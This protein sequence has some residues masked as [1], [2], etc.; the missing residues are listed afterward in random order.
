MFFAVIDLLEFGVA[1]A[2]CFQFAQQEE[3]PCRDEQE[4]QEQ[5]CGPVA[6][7]FQGTFFFLDLEARLHFL[8]GFILFLLDVLLHPEDI[9]VVGVQRLLIVPGACVEPH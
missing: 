6:I 7:A 9:V 2:G 5:Q 3:K 8:Q 4:R 1:A